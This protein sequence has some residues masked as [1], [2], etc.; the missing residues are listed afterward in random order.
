LYDHLRYLEGN[1]EIYDSK[2]SNHYLSDLVGYYV[3]CYFFKDLPGMEQK[4]LWCYEE[5]LKEHKKQIYSDGTSYEGSTAYHRLVT[6][7]FYLFFLLTRQ[8]KIAVPE[9]FEQ[10]LHK[11]FDFIAWNTVNQKEFFQ[12]GDNDSGKIING[13]SRVAMSFSEKNG[14]KHFKD[15]GLSFYKDDGIHFS[16]RHYVFHPMQLAGHFHNDA[17]SVTLA[18]RKIPVIVDPGSY[19][20]TSSRYWRN[21]FRS[22][23]SHNTFYLKDHEPVDLE[24]EDLFY[25]PLICNKFP[26]I[27]EGASVFQ[28]KHQLYEARGLEAVRKVVIDAKTIKLYD[29]WHFLHNAT[30]KTAMHMSAW[31][32]VLYPAINVEYQQNEWCFMHE[33]T[34]LAKM[35]STLSF[36]LIDGWYSPAYGSKQATTIMHAE[37]PLN[38]DQQIT[39]VELC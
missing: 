25:L 19:L 5:L 17:G 21:E 29:Q 16:L 38:E 34:L 7:L 33:G 24:H 6:E 28:T 8:E 20:Y 4:F 3:L 14:I 13:L 10:Q 35:S 12:I 30:E 18:V 22:V 31:R 11:M 2:T 36:S 27:D 32:F 39:I 15:F 1:W 23:A 37:I 26:V 9:W